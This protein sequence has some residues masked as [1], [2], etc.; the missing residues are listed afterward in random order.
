ML[1]EQLDGSAAPPPQN[2]PAAHTP[3]VPPLPLQAIVVVETL[4]YPG[5]Q[6]QPMG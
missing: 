5:A 3:Q 2:V 6:A 4:A 1:H